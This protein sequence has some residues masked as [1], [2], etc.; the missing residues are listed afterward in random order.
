MSTPITPAVLVE[1][2][3]D[4]L[5]GFAAWDGPSPHAYVDLAPDSLDG[6]AAVVDL[7]PDSLDGFAGVTAEPS[8]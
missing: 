5:D 4:N 7:A 8:A 2:E 6:F 3:P 1:L